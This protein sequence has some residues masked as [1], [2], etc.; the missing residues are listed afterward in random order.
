[1]PVPPP[2]APLNPLDYEQVAYCHDE[3]TGLRALISI[4][5]TALGP[6][7]GGTRFYP[8][9]TEQAAVQAV[10]QLSRAMAYKNALCGRDHGGGKAVIS[11]DP[12]TDKSEALLRAYG[13]F[14]ESLGG[15]YVTACDLGTS[16]AG[17]D[18]AAAQ[19]LH[20]AAVRA[21]QRLALV[22][23]TV[24]DDD[25][26]AAAVVAAAQRVLVGHSARNLKDVLEGAVLRLIRVEARAPQRRP[27][28]RGVDA[29][30]RS[31]A[32][33][34]VVAVRDLFVV[35]WV[36]GGGRRRHW[37]GFSLCRAP[38]PGGFDL[39][40]VAGGSGEAHLGTVV[41]SHFGHTDIT[42]SWRSLYRA[43]GR[44]WTY[45]KSAPCQTNPALGGPMTSRAVEAEALL[46]PAEVAALFRVD[47]K[48]VTRWAKAGKL[49][50]LRTLGGHRR[51][52]AEEVRGLLG[53]T[54]IAS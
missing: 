37:H 2:A 18:V 43:D 31:Q 3:A 17:G 20:E 27:Q 53:G 54:E 25:G 12:A 5:S 45:Q 40:D 24:T 23:C 46:T 28:R 48:T 21:Q 33:G 14:V 39:A 32:R 49:T 52:R 26:L 1:M 11:G 9:E 29:D 8:Y 15:R 7:L 36:E 4:Y 44:N 42:L 30:D 35:Q 13:R 51:Y 38:T 6:A 16:V 41:T 22:R 19:T 50:S 10:L 34:L 47:P